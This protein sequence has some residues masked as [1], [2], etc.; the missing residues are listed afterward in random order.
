MVVIL[1]YIVLPL[2]TAWDLT[3]RRKKRRKKGHVTTSH[4]MPYKELIFHVAL[5][6]WTAI[7][8]HRVLSYG[9]SSSIVFLPDPTSLL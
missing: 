8:L 7:L 2:K 5:R 4:A 3:G 1:L 9:D 6:W